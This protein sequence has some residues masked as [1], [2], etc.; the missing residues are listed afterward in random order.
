MQSRGVRCADPSGC[1][2][3]KSPE[4]SKSCTPKLA[5]ESHGGHWF[6]GKI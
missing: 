2:P 1:A 4:T 6:T 3:R 5:C